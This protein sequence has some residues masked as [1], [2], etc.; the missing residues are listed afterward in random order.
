[1]EM[2]GGDLFGPLCLQFIR[3]SLSHAYLFC[4]DVFSGV[5]DGI[6]YGLSAT[7]ET[8]TP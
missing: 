2:L 3:T 4:S 8:V 5:G 6:Q 7:P 1:M